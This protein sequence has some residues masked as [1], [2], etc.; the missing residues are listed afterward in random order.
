MGLADYRQTQNKIKR[1]YTA[2]FN[3]TN[4]FDLKVEMGRTSCNSQS[5]SRRS[6][7]GQSGRERDVEVTVRHLD[8]RAW[9]S[10]GGAVKRQESNVSVNENNSVEVQADE[11]DV[12]TLHTDAHEGVVIAEE[13]QIDGTSEAQ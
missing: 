6:S 12:V 9:A 11:I 4:A 8:G 5:R 3:R 10:T 2:R 1:P 13:D 7:G